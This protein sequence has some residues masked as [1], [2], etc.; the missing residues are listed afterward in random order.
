[1]SPPNNNQHQ[2]VRPSE[3]LPY[4]QGLTIGPHSSAPSDI[5][6]EYEHVLVNASL[7]ASSQLFHRDMSSAIQRNANPKDKSA[8][9]ATIS[10][11]F[12]STSHADQYGCQM[13]IEISGRKVQYLAREQAKKIHVSPAIF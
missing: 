13:S 12:P 3:D 11:T 10:M 5:I 9:V 2:K 7:E 4:H 6:T 1:M 8:L